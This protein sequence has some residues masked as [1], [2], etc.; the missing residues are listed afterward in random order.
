MFQTIKDKTQNLEQLEDVIIFV[1]ELRSRKIKFEDRHFPANLKCLSFNK[2][3]FQDNEK[4]LNLV[5]KEIY[6][7]YSSNHLKSII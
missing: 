7:I 5:F 4:L 6:S 3:V 1:K 2:N